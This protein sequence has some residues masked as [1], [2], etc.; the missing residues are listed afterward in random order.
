[1]IANIW[2]H[3]AVHAYYRTETFFIWHVR[4]DLSP[5]SFE[6]PSSSGYDKFKYLVFY[7][8]VPNGIHANASQAMQFPIL[9]DGYRDPRFCIDMDGIGCSK[10][11]PVVGF[12]R[13]TDAQVHQLFFGSVFH[14][15]KVVTGCDNTRR[16]STKI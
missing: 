4:H 5:A 6:R 15:D 14:A 2:I 12:P 9:L 8:R 1:M 3:F 10:L 11:N 13:T 7:Q 16:H